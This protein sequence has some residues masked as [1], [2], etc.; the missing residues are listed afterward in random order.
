[1]DNPNISVLVSALITSYSRRPPVALLW[2]EFAAHCCDGATNLAPALKIE[3]QFIPPGMTGDGQLLDGPVFGNL[4]PGA[5]HRFYLL[6]IG[7][8]GNPTMQNS[9]ATMVDAWKSISQ[10]EILDAWDLQPEY[11]RP[12]SFSCSDRRKK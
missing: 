2:D 5:R 10:N 3:L 1:M 8:N 7:Q 9:A 6:R 4:K 12:D 11:N